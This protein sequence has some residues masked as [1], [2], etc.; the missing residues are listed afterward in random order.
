MKDARRDMLVIPREK[1]AA[2]LVEHEEARRVRCPD[3]FMGVVHSGAGV[4][5]KMIAVDEDRTVRRIVRP[6][7]RA[8]REIELPENV[9]IER[10][11]L[12]RRRRGVGAARR[13]VSA[14]V[15]E[16]PIVSVRHSACIETEHHSAVIHKIDAVLFDG[17][18][19]ADAALRPVII[20][21]FL[22]LGHDQLPEQLAAP[23]VE[24]HQ[25]ATVALIFRVARLAIVRA[26]VNPSARDHRSRMRVSP[27]PCRP[28]DV[29]PGLRIKG[30]RQSFLTRNHVARPGLAPLRLIGGEPGKVRAGGGEEPGQQQA[31]CRTV[32]GDGRRSIRGDLLQVA[33]HMRF[34]RVPQD[35]PQLNSVRTAT[36][37]SWLRAP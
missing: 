31:S 26:D 27:E 25:H 23:F 32:F 37:P 21:V 18:G 19:R 36:R 24:T 6:D 15:A 7:A 1:P 33:S 11:D 4:E 17:R 30:V 13:Q 12:N 5:V 16:W 29:T 3:A 34:R 2:T 8:T 14:F 20:L 35:A 28:P 9:R 22:P 10:P